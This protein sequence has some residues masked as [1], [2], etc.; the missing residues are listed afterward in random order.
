MKI[1]RVMC[2]E[3]VVENS[4]KFATTYFYST[5]SPNLLFSLDAFLL[6]LAINF[7]L[8]FTS[9]D[10]KEKMSATIADLVRKHLDPLNKKI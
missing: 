8:Q 10:D 2:D 7:L 1:G 6:R 5:S 4:L 3:G 9:A